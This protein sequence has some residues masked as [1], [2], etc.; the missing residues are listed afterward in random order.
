VARV[1]IGCPRP[2]D[3]A[4]GRGS[5]AAVGVFPGQRRNT[6]V[7]SCRGGAPR[8]LPGHGVV[9]FESGRR[10]GFC[11]VEASARVE[12]RLPLGRAQRGGVPR[13]PGPWARLIFPQRRLGE[14]GLTVWE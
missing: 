9:E 10:P 14:L 7:L 5:G 12:R 4:P 3:P 11:G 2:A 8:G 6:A 1:R 13:G